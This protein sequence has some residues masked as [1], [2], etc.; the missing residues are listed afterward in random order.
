MLRILGLSSLLA[1]LSACASAP[2]VESDPL[3]IDKPLETV[4]ENP[5]RRVSRFIDREGVAAA[6]A[7]ALPDIV[8]RLPAETAGID[9]RQLDLLGNALN[10][11]LCQRLGQ[12]LL[13]EADASP[14]ALRIEAALT[15]ITPTSKTA[16]GLSA[17]VDVFVPGPFRIPVGMG[18]IALDA[19]ASRADGTVVLMR[20]AK[21]ANP[22][23]NSA[24]V[25]TIGDAYALLDTFAK[26][27]T[28]WLVQDAD[29]NGRR[30]KLAEDRIEANESLCEA[31][32]G[33]IDAFGRGA[34]RLI[35][36]APEA[37]DNGRPETAGDSVQEDR[38][39]A[40]E[41]PAVRR[42]PMPEPAVGEVEPRFPRR[43]ERGLDG[44]PIAH[45]AQVMEF[46]VTVSRA[47]RRQRVEVPS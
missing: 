36:L 4:A 47:V 14:E 30:P 19:R 20:W 23:F 31:R 3:A 35:P 28:Y 9:D 33:K 8:L 5:D 12:Y 32:Y 43:V 21:G 46:A 7:F 41:V 39:A 45:L 16:A 38:A 29:G 1:I 27:F 6:T 2:R 34:S 24:K 25:S 44:R 26:E 18:S 11:S 37:I 22:L 10:R 42:P 15:G 17:A 13:A 40:P